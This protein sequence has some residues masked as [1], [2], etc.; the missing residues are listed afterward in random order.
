MER[1]SIKNYN[2]I[3]DNAEQGATST[4]EQ[5]EITIA[6]DEVQRT[7]GD[8]SITNNN[9]KYTFQF[10]D[11]TRLVNG[12]EGLAINPEKIVDNALYYDKNA[13]ETR[14][15]NVKK[16]RTTRGQSTNLISP[17]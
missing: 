8:T 1:T 6:L 17:E 15:Q 7:Y 16:G 5:A 14:T 12:D 11:G 9:G 10:A 2:I 3:I 13:E 4:V